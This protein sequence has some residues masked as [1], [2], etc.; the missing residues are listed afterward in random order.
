MCL[1]P[2]IIF[3]PNY[4]QHRHEFQYIYIKGQILQQP[5]LSDS[6]YYPI[7]CITVPFASLTPDSLCNYLA[8][9][10]DGEV[11][12]IFM[13]VPCGKCLE[14]IES[15]RSQIRVRMYLEQMSHDVPPIFVT[16][17]YNNENLPADGVSREDVK[18]FLNRFHL[19][20]GRAGRSTYFR[21]VFF[22]EYGSLNGR[23]HYHGIIFG[24][25]VED[26]YK[27]KMEFFD[28]L[29]KAWGKG[30]VRFDI[31][32]SRAFGYVSK[33][34]GKDSFLDDRLGRNPNFWTASRRDGGLGSGIVTTDAF[35][36]L[37]S[38]PHF[39]TVNLPCEG[40]IYTVTLPAYIRDKVLP[41]L[42]KY[43]SREIRDAY[44]QFKKDLCL[45]KCIDLDFSKFHESYYCPDLRFA[46]CAE[47]FRDFSTSSQ[48]IARYHCT[49]YARQVI[50]ELSPIADK[51]DYL[52]GFYYGS[53][54]YWKFQFE[55]LPNRFDYNKLFTR[56][57]RNAEIL[58]SVS[59]DVPYLLTQI[60]IRDRVSRRF[61]SRVKK[62]LEELP[63]DEERAKMLW[64][65]N[66]RDFQ[67]RFKDLQ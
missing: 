21:H 18:K 55:H 37:C 23:P 28:I 27:D 35:L 1:A 9:T 25:S 32:H 15:K 41:P 3:N 67:N 16:L 33:Y 8:I 34:I 44:I 42:R 30:Y 11:V 60:S 38:T 45:L 5:N 57:Y 59:L 46:D 65:K 14:C 54:E 49:K 29:E 17:T 58:S 39:P 26:T 6:T 24:H 31:V 4:S 40:K 50:E 66:I 13:A 64:F 10:P 22:S 47:E 63:P 56:L 62:H 19:Y 48:L 61:I 53:D 2:N 7:D 52:L 36:E 20:L 51:Y 43:I 12:P